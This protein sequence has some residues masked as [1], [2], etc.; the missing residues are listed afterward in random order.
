M[1]DLIN[2]I[3]YQN[4]ISKQ[5]SYDDYYIQELAKNKKEVFISTPEYEL[6]FKKPLTPIRKYFVRLIENYFIINLNQI[7]NKEKS[8]LLKEEFNYYYIIFEKQIKSHFSNLSHY[9]NSNNLFEDLYLTSQNLKSD[10]AYIIHFIKHQLVMLYMELQK[11]F[12]SKI[13]IELLNQNEIYEIFLFENITDKQHKIIPFKGIKTPYKE[14]VIENKAAF[15][16]I[17]GDLKNREENTKVITYDDLINKKDRFA[18]L[19]AKLFEEKIIDI[20]FKFIA[21]KGNKI[22]LAAFI[23]KIKNKGYFN[24]MVFTPVQKMISDTMII[25]FLKH[26]YQTDMR[27]E[28]KNFSGADPHAFKNIIQKTYW[29]DN[30][31]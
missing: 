15:M 6:E 9:I 20:N 29:L 27:K 13:Q 7:I 14:T 21:T 28:F 2:Y 4:P 3:L 10:E 31:Q 11:R 30:I 12:A 19:E 18:L 1:E 25:N 26:R 8:D 16:P 22:I 24:K 17:K 5:N 23:L